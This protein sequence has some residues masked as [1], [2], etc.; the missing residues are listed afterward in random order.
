LNSLT[1]TFIHKETKLREL[2]VLKAEI[3]SKLNIN[4]AHPLIY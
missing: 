1:T 2:G 4:W 3:A